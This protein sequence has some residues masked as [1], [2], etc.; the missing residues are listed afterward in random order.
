MVKMNGH[1]LRR[2]QS[3]HF[4]DFSAGHGRVKHIFG[5]EQAAAA[6]ADRQREQAEKGRKRS[7][8]PFD[9]GGR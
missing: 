1:K 4:T 9:R 5:P 2:P 6:V 7:R 3:F 8:H